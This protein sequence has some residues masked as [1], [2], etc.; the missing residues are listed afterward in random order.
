MQ[1]KVTL[2]KLYSKQQEI[3]DGLDNHRYVVAALARRTGKTITGMNVA[4][5]TALNTGLPILWCSISY[6]QL[7]TT[8]DM[9]VDVVENIAT[10][11]NRQQNQI[12]LL[13]GS[14]IDFFSLDNVSSDSIRGKKYILCIIDEAAFAK[15]LENIFYSVIT[16]TL[17][18]YQG[19]CLFISSPNGRN[20]FFKFHQYSQNYDDW[21]SL[22]ATTYDNPYIKNSELDRLK[23]VLPK[24][25]FDTEILGEFVGEGKLFSNVLELSTAKEEYEPVDGSVYVIGIDLAFQNDYTAI[26]VLDITRRQV[27]RVI[28]CQYELQALTKLIG[29]VNNLYKSVRINIDATGM[30]VPI[31]HALRPLNLPLNPVTFTKQIKEY[32]IHNLII[33]LE[34]RSITLVNNRHMIDELSLFEEKNGKYNAPSGYT[35]DIV[36]ALALACWELRNTKNE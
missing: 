3:V 11:I 17:T 1:Y 27:V 36:I 23:E 29:D 13:N 10:R 8:F 35:D 4:I 22:T 9:F 5:T 21:F 26:V 32:L 31:I 15:D 25:V 6:K 28:K 24:K 34:Q 14:R 20:T 18:D 33:Q 30:G 19:K 2:P 16:P 12:K 7:S